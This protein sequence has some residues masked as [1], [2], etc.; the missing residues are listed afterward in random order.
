MSFYGQSNLKKWVGWQEPIRDQ[1]LSAFEQINKADGHFT[2]LWVLFENSFYD[3][4]H[5]MLYARYWFTNCSRATVLQ[6]GPGPHSRENALLPYLRLFAAIFCPLPSTDRFL[7][8]PTILF[9]DNL[10]QDPYKTW[11]SEMGHPLYMAEPSL[12]AFLDTRNY[13]GFSVLSLQF[14]VNL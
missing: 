11:N 9:Q 10:S 12:S 13:I 2:V 6:K 4:L 7:C 8:H 1:K 14:F 5:I 3:I